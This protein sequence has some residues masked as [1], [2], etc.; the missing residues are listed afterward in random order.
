MWKVIGTKKSLE[1]IYEPEHIIVDECKWNVDENGVNI[2]SVDPAHVC[3]VKLTV[4]KEYFKE[5]E[6]D[7]EQL[8]LGMNIQ[9]MEKY[10]K[11]WGANDE[12]TIEKL[13]DE[14]RLKLSGGNIE[15]KMPLLDTAGMTD[16]NVPQLDLP[17]ITEFEGR[18][19]KKALKGVGNVSDHIKIVSNANGITFYA[20][21]DEDSIDIDVEQSQCES[22]EVGDEVVSLFNNEYH[23]AMAGIVDNDTM[24]EIHLGKDYPVKMF[25]TLTGEDDSEAEIDVEFLVAPRIESE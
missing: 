10:F 14:H 18:Y 25:F 8:E 4:P 2:Q 15:Y 16:P 20:S 5:W 3:M 17:N 7:G 12:I 6:F 19:Y 9:K 11:V 21:E 13:E 1:Q 22:I 23:K 24:L